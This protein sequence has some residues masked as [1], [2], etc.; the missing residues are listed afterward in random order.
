MTAIRQALESLAAGETGA[1]VCRF[2]GNGTASREE[3]L[4]MRLGKEQAAGY[5]EDTGVDEVSAEEVTV[6]PH[7]EAPLT[8]AAGTASAGTASAGTA[9]ADTV[10]ADSVL[11]DSVASDSAL[12]A[13]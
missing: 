13:G 11:A 10:Q 5:V 3:V 9:S 4:D 1:V 6:A 7:R 12:T 8:A 2:A